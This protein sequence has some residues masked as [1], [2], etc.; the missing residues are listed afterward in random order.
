MLVFAIRPIFEFLTEYYILRVSR[1]YYKR[2]VYTAER[3]SKELQISKTYDYL[4]FLE[5]HA[6]P[7]Y[8][9]YYKTANTSIMVFITLIFGPALPVLYIISLVSIGSQY[10]IERLS[11]AYF[12]RLPP[13][14]SDKLTLLNLKIMS[15]AP[16]LSLAFT[17]WIYNNGQMFGNRIDP[18]KTQT[19]VTLS[20]HTF[21][22]IK[23]SKL[24]DNEKT[25]VYAIIVLGFYLIL[26]N[27]HRT[28]LHK[29]EKQVFEDDPKSTTPNYYSVLKSAECVQILEDEDNFRKMGFKGLDD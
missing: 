22:T 14:Y 15:F 20:H 2:F 27:L 21:A 25:I 7:E 5:C 18:I 24:N 13:K 26:D 23:W 10:F 1:W 3:K 9:F 29:H 6:G 4:E 11:L 12:Y 16:I 8:P 19:D 17:F 28:F